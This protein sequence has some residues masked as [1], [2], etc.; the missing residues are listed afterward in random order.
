ML[1][2]HRHKDAVKQSLGQ[3]AQDAE[4]ELRRSCFDNSS[5]ATKGCPVLRS[6]FASDS[7]DLPLWAVDS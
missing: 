5:L 6:N 2:R 4:E 3:S 1:A 7:N